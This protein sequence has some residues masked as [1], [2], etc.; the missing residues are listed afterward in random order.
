[1]K[2]QERLKHACLVVLMLALLVGLPLLT[3]TEVF[4][5]GSADGVSGASIE[6][7]DQPSGDF[8][9]LLKTDLHR[10]S[11]ADWESFFH[12]DEDFAVIF[13]DV[14]CLVADGDATGMQLAERFQAQLPENQM[15]VRTEN[16][17]MLASKAEAGY[18][19]MAIFSSEMMDAMKIRTESISDTITVIHVAG[20]DET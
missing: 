16:A 12:D 13:E 8:V 14:Q 9:V 19:D 20:G 7:P 5:S 1:M 17:T 4:G 2:K 3:H 10:D 6:L 15:K 18:I 11:L